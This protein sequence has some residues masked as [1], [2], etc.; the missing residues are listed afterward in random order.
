MIS[1]WIFLPQKQRGL[2]SLSLSP[3]P[4]PDAELHWQLS[5]SSSS[6]LRGGAPFRSGPG[7]GSKAVL[8]TPSSPLAGMCSL[9]TVSLFVSLPFVKKEFKINNAPGAFFSFFSAITHNFT[10]HKALFQT[11]LLPRLISPSH[12]L[13]VECCRRTKKEGSELQYGHS[14]DKL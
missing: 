2:N 10:S 1:Q 13:N 8:E 12:I 11:R 14:I 9:Q 7:S 5:D 6:F 4:H 3:P